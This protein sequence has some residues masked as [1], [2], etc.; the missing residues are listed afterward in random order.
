MG[1]G[2]PCDNGDPPFNVYA[3]NAPVLRSCGLFLWLPLREL[4]E[5]PNRL[6]A[7]A[8]GAQRATAGLTWPIFGRS[9]PSS[10]FQGLAA[11]VYA[12]RD[13]SID[14][15]SIANITYDGDIINTHTQSDV[16]PPFLRHVVPAAFFAWHDKSESELQHMSYP[17]RA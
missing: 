6:S 5:T 4:P 13:G 2:R 8:R 16:I 9:Q 17:E 14:D 3:S 7:R 11:S 15:N 12:E 10:Q 1:R